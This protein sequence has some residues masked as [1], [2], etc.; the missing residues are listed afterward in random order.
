MQATC[1]QCSNK[2]T[3]DDAK[4]PDRAFSVKCPRC[5][6]T[7]KLPGRGAEGTAGPAASA[8]AGVAVS[9]DEMKAQVMAQLRREMGAAEGSAG[10]ALVVLP[11]R[12]LAGTVTLV[13]T[14]QGY[15]VDTIDDSDEGGRLVEQGAYAMVATARTAAAAGKESLHQR[16]NR[17]S[18]DA[19]RRLFLV[20]VGDDFRTGDG[21]QAF[22]LLADLVVN[23]RDAA[24]ADT[25]LRNTVAERTRLYQAMGDARRRMEAS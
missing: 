16:I 19:R 21:T 10:R 12:A 15:A 24:T 5:Q 3:I 22:A 13:L 25:A 18:P 23:S 2:L 14:R 8:P 20:L 7:L 6:A 1:P 9:A 4:V 17:L 11:D